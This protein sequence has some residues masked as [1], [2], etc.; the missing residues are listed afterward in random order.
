MFVEKVFQLV[1]PFLANLYST[2]SNKYSYMYSMTKKFL[3]LFWH[4]SIQN[5]QNFNA[6]F[7]SVEIIRKKSTQKKLFAKYFCKLVVQEEK[8]R[9]FTLF[10][11]INFLLANIYVFLNSF[12]FSIKLCNVLIPIFKFCKE[13]VFM[14]YQHF[15]ETLKPDSQETAQ[16]FE[17]RIL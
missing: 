5:T 13:K 8:L 15:F 17:K 11:A 3:I 16:D 4:I 6:D 9:F 12:E 2:S 1:K 14:S 10:L 7:K